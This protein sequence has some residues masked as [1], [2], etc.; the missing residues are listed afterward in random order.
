MLICVRSDLDNAYQLKQ[1][2]MF[3]YLISSLNS[4][5]AVYLKTRLRGGAGANS[6]DSASQ[7]SATETVLRLIL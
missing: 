4:T 6:Q 7:K 1:I 5:P 2:S 3:G